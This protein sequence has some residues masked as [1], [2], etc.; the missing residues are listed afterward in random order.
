M[1]PSRPIAPADLPLSQGREDTPAPPESNGAAGVAEGL[2]LK[3]IEKR[4]ILEA[5]A[6]CGGNRSKAA[7]IL[8]IDRSTLRRKLQEFGIE[9][10]R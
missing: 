6:H 7:R 4:A 3:E 2:S 8:E 9:S 1:T 10:K 5:I